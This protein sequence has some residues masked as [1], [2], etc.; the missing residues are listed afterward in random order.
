ML[1][2]YQCTITLSIYGDIYA[3]MRV[4]ALTV[5]PYANQCDKHDLFSIC[6]FH[7]VAACL[8]LKR[9]HTFAI[10]N[11]SLSNN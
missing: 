11:N 4:G 6:T 3:C 9:R 10:G 7:S 5:C 8:T 2:M 1:N